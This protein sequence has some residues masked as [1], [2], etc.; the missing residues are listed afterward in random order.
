MNT[1]RSK[2]KCA[3]GCGTELLPGRLVCGAMWKRVPQETRSYIMLPTEP[4]WK[5]AAVRRVLE[6]AREVAREVAR[7]RKQEVA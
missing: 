7:Q 1:T 4:Q 6:M 2:R 5:R 3:C